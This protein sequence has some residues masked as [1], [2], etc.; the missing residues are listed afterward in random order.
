MKLEHSSEKLP[1]FDVQKLLS[2]LEGD[3][4]AAI[5]FIE[6]SEIEI[7]KQ[8]DLLRE[9][10]VA[11][12]NRKLAHKLK[13]TSSTVGMEKLKAIA[14]K[15]ESLDEAEFNKATLLIKAADNEFEI[16]KLVIKKEIAYLKQREL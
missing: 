5:S 14:Y 1:S 15:L 16:V 4:D 2:L 11:A 6:M 8:L 13:G 12:N 10:T 7:K 3:T 9:N